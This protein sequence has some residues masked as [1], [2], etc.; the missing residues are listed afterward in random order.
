MKLNIFAD[1]LN[2]T[3]KARV[4]DKHIFDALGR[5]YVRCV[6]GFAC[7]AMLAGF[8]LIGFRDPY[9]IRPLVIGSRL[10]DDGSGYDWMM[11]SESIALKQR[12]F[13]N[14]RDILPGQAVIIPKVGE[15]VFRQVQPAISY[16][17][18]I[19]EYVYFARPDSVIDG[20]S[21]QLCRERMGERLAAQ[22]KKFLVSLTR[23]KPTS[24]DYSNALSRPLKSWRR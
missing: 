4:N 5:M 10:S 11:A 3:G 6:G 8:G 2:K 18:D 1:E 17:P 13:K 14:I 20:M 19:F 16:T 7:T 9:G 15:P 24:E 23:C 22:I 12:K 21:V